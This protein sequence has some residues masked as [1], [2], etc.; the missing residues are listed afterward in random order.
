MGMP[1]VGTSAANWGVNM[2][3]QRSTDDSFNVAAA[4][5]FAGF[6]SPSAAQAPDAAS[7][8]APAAASHAAELV[9]EIREI[10]DGMWAIDR[11]SVEVRFKFDNDEG[12]AVRVEYRDGTVKATFRTDSEQLRELIAREWQSQVAGADSRA[13]R[14]ADPIFEARPANADSLSSDA[15]GSRQQSQ[16]QPRSA[17]QAGFSTHFSLSNERSGSATT[18]GT[19]PATDVRPDTAHHLHTFA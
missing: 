19:S 10:A 9:H 15:G 6:A 18:L 5:T 2:N 13:Y 11:N 3:P 17:D 1:P 8:L 7:A 16:G 4:Q 14:M 12:L